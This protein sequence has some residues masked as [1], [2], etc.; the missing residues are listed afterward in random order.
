MSEAPQTVGAQPGESPKERVDRELRE[1]LEEIRVALPGLELLFGFLLILPFTERFEIITGVQRDVYLACF[2]T[3]AA[4]TALL[5]APTARHRLGFR[6]VDKELLLRDA[7]RQV[8]AGLALVAFAFA[9]AI[10]LAVAVMVNAT[11]AAV[12]SAA[13][14][15]WFAVWWFVFPLWRHRAAAHAP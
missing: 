11:W 5:M 13:V 4:A 1:L 10:Y 9:L 15:G 8:I 12:L 6:E 7:N 14:G 3:T 2:V